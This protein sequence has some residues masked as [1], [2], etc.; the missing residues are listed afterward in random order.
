MTWFFAEERWDR[1]EGAGAK[2]K[3]NKTVSRYSV[4]KV[5]KLLQ[6]MRKLGVKTTND[7]KWETRVNKKK[8]KSTAFVENNIKTLGVGGGI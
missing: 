1:E 8:K 2:M 6:E 5:K 3:I 7:D 4:R